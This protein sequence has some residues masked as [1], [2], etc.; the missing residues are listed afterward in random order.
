[1]RIACRC[2]KCQNLF[3]Q[4]EDDICLEFDFAEKNI[5]FV[6]RNKNCNHINIFDFGAWKEEQQ[7]SP[8][9]GIGLVR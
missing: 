7:K 5:R 1:M 6:C 3:I 2:E 9:P 8:Y 4:D